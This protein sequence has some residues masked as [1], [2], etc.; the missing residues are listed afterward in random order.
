MIWPAVILGSIGCYVLKLVG[1]LLP[2]D[3]LNSPR[4]R[5]VAGLMPVALLAALVAVQTFAQ[6]QQLVIDG[7]LAGLAAA[8]IALIL[9]APFLVVILVAA[10]TAA[11]LRAAGWAA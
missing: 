2:D 3:T 9:R 5:H 8:I 11:L 7:R 1:Y 10:A 6:G 4:V